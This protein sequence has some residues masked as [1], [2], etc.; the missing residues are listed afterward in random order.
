MYF[1]N[2]FSESA[3]ALLKMAARGQENEAVEKVKSGELFVAPADHRP[4]VETLL[5]IKAPNLAFTLASKIHSE[6]LASAEAAYLHALTNIYLNKEDAAISI[7]TEATQHH[8][9]THDLLIVVGLA[10][11]AVESLDNAGAMFQLTLERGG[12]TIALAYLAEVLRLMKRNKDALACFDQCFT[13]GCKDAEAF[14]LAGN[15]YYDA[16]Q[17]DKAI[18]NYE[19]SV[20]VKP[21]YIDSH[22]A[23]NKTIWEH[24]QGKRLLN[25][26]E[27]A[28]AIHPDLLELKLKRAQYRV[29]S[30]ALETAWRELD[31]SVQEY[32]RIPRLM[33]ELTKVRQLLM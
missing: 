14:Y 15:A 2:E 6:N 32:G 29:V 12:P 4:L 5:A 10:M 30:G 25:S 23:L 1:G 9:Q 31:A 27:A 21:W 26:I 16:G 7:A 3:A 19:K 17:I 28:I 22:D 18:Q 11:L 13:R 8:G 20:E 24:R 33:N